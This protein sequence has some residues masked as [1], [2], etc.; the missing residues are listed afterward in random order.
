MIESSSSINSVYSVIYQELWFDYIGRDNI[1]R[2][3]KKINKEIK[4]CLCGTVEANRPTSKK[5]KQIT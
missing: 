5:T 2:N 3:I 1:K 4:K